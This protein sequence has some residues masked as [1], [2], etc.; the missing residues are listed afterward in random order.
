MANK[1][2]PI[3]FTINSMELFLKGEG[4]MGRHDA[5]VRR[6]V[7]VHTPASHKTKTKQKAKNELRSYY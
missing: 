1:K 2:K 6:G 3:T 7:G 5:E 4:K